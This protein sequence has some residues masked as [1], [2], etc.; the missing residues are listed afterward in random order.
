ML[1]R[2]ASEA[3]RVGR[4]TAGV[5]HHQR[6]RRLSAQ[7]ACAGSA[8]HY[9]EASARYGSEALGYET[10]RARRQ[11]CKE[12]SDRGGGE[13]TGDPAAPSV[14]ERR[15]IRAAE[16]GS[17]HGESGLKDS[18]EL[19]QSPGSGDCERAVERKPRKRG[20]SVRF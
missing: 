17:G 15:S 3:E 1:C 12:A 9:G 20:G 10:G 14:G 7:V 11:E 4:A 16:E 19:A 13:K 6:R 2:F 8:L 18:V 5:A